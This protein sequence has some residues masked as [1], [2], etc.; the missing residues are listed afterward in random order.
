MTRWHNN[1]NLPPR[2]AQ[3]VLQGH[4]APVLTVVR[5]TQ[6]NN[7]EVECVW[8][9]YN[10]GVERAWLPADLPRDPPRKPFRAR[11]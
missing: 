5:H 11:R 8:F 3:K 1:P 7:G 2:G 9:N 10:G 4:T 6:Y